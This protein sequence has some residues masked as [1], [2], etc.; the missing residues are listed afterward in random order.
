[1]EQED[2]RSKGKYKVIC[3]W[4]R[5]GKNM[6]SQL[7]H[8]DVSQA[9]ANMLAKALV[10][11]KELRGYVNIENP[12]YSGNLSVDMPWLRKI[13]GCGKEEGSSTSISDEIEVRCLNASGVEDYFDE[14]MTY[15]SE[16]HTDAEMLWVYDRNGKKQ[17][18]FSDRFVVVSS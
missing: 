17:E 4:G 14:G 2:N 15:I 16:G 6:T 11:D 8:G 13:I 5:N 9:E 18:C 10:R 12:E 3:R 7:K 1:V